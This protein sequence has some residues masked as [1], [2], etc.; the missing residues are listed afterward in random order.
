MM[1]DFL[2]LGNL[3][4]HISKATIGELSLSRL[5]HARPLPALRYTNHP[6]LPLRWPPRPDIDDVAN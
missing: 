2:R 1:L 4:F 6:L 5:D 3:V